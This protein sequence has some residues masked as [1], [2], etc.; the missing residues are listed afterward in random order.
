MATGKYAKV[1]DTLPRL[2]GTDAPYQEKVEAVKEA[3]RAEADYKQQGAYL[4]IKFAI[5]RA[6]KDVV[7]E[8]LKE[9]NLR[10]EAITQLMAEQYEVEGVTSLRLHT[11][12][13]V[14][15]QMEPY[16]VVNEREDFRLW[17]CSNGYE[18][19]LMLPWQTTNAITK[20]RLLE[21]EPEPHG[22]KCY[23]KVKAVF[24]KA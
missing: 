14:R 24:T 8:N 22:V 16:A 17:C 5:T 21:G 23:S 13:S 15:I 19:S 9:V 7:E 4:A 20:E 2:L 10:L 18:R 6:E 12:A 11:G 3:M 1:I